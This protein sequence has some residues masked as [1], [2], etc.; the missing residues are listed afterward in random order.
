M[1]AQDLVKDFVR[2]GFSSEDFYGVLN[3]A[4]RRFYGEDLMLHYPICRRGTES[5]LQCQKN[6]T[7]YCLAKL[8]NL[9]GQ[10][11][12]EIGCGNGVQSV[13]ILENCKPA[14][15]TAVDLSLDNIGIARERSNPA[16]HLVYL[17]DDAQQLSHIRDE[18][19]DTVI[20][21]ESAFHYPDKNRFLHQIN[22]VLKP[23]GRFLI[24]DILNRGA[25]G[26]K[27][28]S[29]WQRRMGLNHWT[30]DEYLNGF[31]ANDLQIDHQEEMTAMILH[32]YLH[33]RIWSRAF[34]AQRLIYALMGYTWARAM[35]AINCLLLLT[36]R[37]YYLFVGRKK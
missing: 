34:L 5:L 16:D 37:R 19:I 2:V 22:R 27:T 3:R 24:A 23:D 8:P 6:L 15:I 25:Y 31:R 17:L 32:G 26:S 12:L 4:Y 18:S 30:L 35:A 7:D 14:G 33:A 13:Y 1:S 29:F 20:N 9:C 21:I 28:L 36:L 10:Q 11:V